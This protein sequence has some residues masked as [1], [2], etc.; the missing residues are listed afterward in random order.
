M[1]VDI[2]DKTAV[3][4]KDILA[5]NFMRPRPSVVFRRHFRQGLR[6]HVLEVLDPADVEAERSGRM[7]DGLLCFP[8]ARPRKMFRVFRTRFRD[9]ADGIEETRRVKTVERFLSPDFMA[10]SNEFLVD[11][12]IEEEWD[13]LLCGLQEYVEGEALDPW[14]P[15][16]EGLLEEIASRMA[17]RGSE[18]SGASAALFAET[19]RRLAAVFVDRVK[20]M[21]SEAAL[22]PDLAGVS[23]LILTPSGHIKL[24][25]INNI[26]PVSLGPGISLDDK[27]YPICD[28]SVQALALLERNLLGRSPAP[29]EPV[30][31]VFLDPARVREVKTAE[32]AFHRSQET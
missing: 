19:V 13:I 17:G 12:R 18:P 28:K 16:G 23:N 8:R 26:S 32:D 22:I 6:S 31:R 14:S 1:T 10:R 29:D 7:R 24:V 9:L 25:D 21:I 5:L 11:Y 20:R 30:Y 2:R 3:G 4:Q 27:G 15:A